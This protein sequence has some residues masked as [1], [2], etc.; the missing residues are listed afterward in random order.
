MLVCGYPGVPVYY[1]TVPSAE[2]LI[3]VVENLINKHGPPDFFHS[4][5]GQA[6]ISEKFTRLLKKYNI[7]QSI[8]DNAEFYFDN[9][10]IES[11]NSVLSRY[12]NIN[13]P[14][15]EGVKTFLKKAR[16]TQSK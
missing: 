8:A 10:V 14:N 12:L 15:K 2:I 3:G 16:S 7:T 5:K 9:Q 1:G 6:Y 4:D 11:I 13:K